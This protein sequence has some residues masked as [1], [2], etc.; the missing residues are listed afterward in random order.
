MAADLVA[1][2]EDLTV[3]KPV[4]DESGNVIIW[5][6]QIIGK[7]EIKTALRCGKLQDLLDLA[8]VS[9]LEEHENTA[10]AAEAAAE[11][12]AEKTEDAAA[13]EAMEE[14]PV[15][16]EDAAFIAEEAA[17]WKKQKKKIRKRKGTVC[18]CKERL[19]VWSPALRRW[20]L[21]RRRR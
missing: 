18:F 12:P 6:G 21:C 20:F 2:L 17:K 16:E 14:Q 3:E 10:E 19:A 7:E 9:L 4:L 5:P 13:D 8:T 11:S 15:S 1:Q